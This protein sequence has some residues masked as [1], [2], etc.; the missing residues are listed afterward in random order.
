MVF[1]EAGGSMGQ[2][3]FSGARLFP[4]CVLVECSHSM[5]H[6]LDQFARF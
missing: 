6:M 3:D 2:E 4:H 5:E 1:G